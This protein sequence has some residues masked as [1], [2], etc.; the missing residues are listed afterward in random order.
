MSIFQGIVLGVLQ[1]I[2]EFLPISS[3]GHLIV[4]QNL[5][6]LEEVPLL[7]DVFLHVA[8]LLAVV[9]YFRK[10]IWELICSFA[11]IFVPVKNPSAVQIEK[12]DEDTKYIVAIILA[13]FV[14]GVLGIFSSK[15][16]SEISVK[17]VCAGFVVTALLLIFSSLIEKKHLSYSETS[18]KSPSWKQSLVIGLAQGIGTLPGISRSGSTIAGSLFCGVKRDVA[19]EFSFIVSIPAILG[20]FILELKDLGE[21]S[22]SIGAEPVIAGCAAA[23]A[24]GYIALSWLMRL[25]KK[26]RLEWFACYLI[27]V[28]ILGMIFLH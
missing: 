10:K 13:T 5:F 20:A 27:P 24:S 23:F 28:G 14:T 3:S 1:G 12:K 7:F 25:I 17:L 15:V 2:A 16:I 21:V 4:A 26:G 19:G 9:L 8:T 11:R 6:G 18:L 22:S